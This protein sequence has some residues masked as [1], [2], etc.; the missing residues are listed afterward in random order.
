MPL[1]TKSY[2][3]HDN[4]GRPFLVYIEPFNINAT[5]VHVYEISD[6]HYTH[7]P[8]N[9]EK[10]MYI[11]LVKTYHAQN[12]WVANGY[13]YGRVGMYDD[14]LC[15]WEDD[16]AIGNSIIIQ[17]INNVFVFVGDI[18]REFK[19]E[20]QDTV[21]NYYS[22]VGRNDVPYPVIIGNNNVYFLLGNDFVYISI[23]EFSPFTKKEQINAYCEFYQLNNYEQVINK[24]NVMS[25]VRGSKY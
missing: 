4:G 17:N 9:E 6:K 24:I 18:V 22:P 14:T 20:P 19:L 1:N 16:F 3:T 11:S 7:N 2:F 21:V 5:S 12:V 10:W 25:K 13:N 15:V 8:Y 23:N